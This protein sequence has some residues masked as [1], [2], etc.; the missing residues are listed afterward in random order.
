M[1][2]DFDY[3]NPDYAPIFVARSQALVKLKENPERVPALRAYYR[4]NI[5][6]FINDWGIIHEPRNPERGLPAKIP[7][8]LFPKQVEYV[9]WFI[10]RW[11][12]QEDGLCEKSRDMGIS[13]LSMAISVSLCLFNEDLVVGAGSRKEEYVDDAHDPKSLFWKAR[14]F[15]EHLP[16]EFRGGYVT[17]RHATFM[18]IS[19]P[20]SRS[21]MTGEAGNNIGRG[22]RT[23]FYI[24]DEAAHLEYPQ[25]IDAALS[26]TTNCRI[27]VSSVNGS[28]NPFA[29][30]RRSGKVSVFT[31][32][33]RNDPRKDDAWYAKQCARLD[34]ITVA[35]E[36]DI[37]YSASV[38]G[39]LI[40]SAWVQAS[41][42]AHVK[43]GITPSGVRHGALDVA[44]EGT[45]INAY[46]GRHGILL[47]HL[48]GWSGKGDD[49]FGTTQRAFMVTDNLG[50]AGFDYDADGLGAGVRG[51]AR[52]INDLRPD[53]ELTVTPYRGSGEIV[54]PDKAIPS[55][56]PNQKKD[57]YDRTNGD[58]FAN[59][60]AQAW[61]GLRVRFQATYRAVVE[62]MEYDP[63]MIIS[64][65]MTLPDRDKLIMELSQPTYSVNTGGKI[66]ID[67]KPSGSCSPNYADAVVMVFRQQT[68]KK[69]GYFT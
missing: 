30:K 68:V 26:A 67:K 21:I 40:P 7:F 32:S 29:V 57:K 27:D 34:P 37:S 54:D 1:K 50:Y 48:E 44:D 13:W 3:R 24:V 25:L 38:E 49:L 46:A 20:Q 15:L 4:E 56:I 28:S 23:S 6:Q 36:I 31:F 63:D 42:D 51:D 61:W 65:P 8:V 16:P 58:F 60:K 9:D 55:A 41:L 17:K 35:Q 53:R 45:D 19:F 39:I 69:R 5:A 14:S 10:A 47:E 59:A 22:A 64:I 52:V 18:R 43:L 12:G 66:L 11:R 2:T 33:W 62:K